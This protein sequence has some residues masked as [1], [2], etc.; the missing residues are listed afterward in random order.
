M[1]EVFADTFYWLALLNPD[2]AYYERVAGF[3]LAGRK[4]ITTEAVRIETMDGLC[5]PRLRPSG[6]RF[7]AITES[8]PE[9][10]ILAIDRDLLA[11][12]ADLFRRRPDKDWS[13]TDCLSFAVMADRG[14]RTALTGDRHFEQAGFDI[15]FK[16]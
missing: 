8:D 9:L 15:A 1:T 3:D 12:A 11:R 10:T 2:D 7:W 5:S 13:L 6:V 4:V 16:S 14:I